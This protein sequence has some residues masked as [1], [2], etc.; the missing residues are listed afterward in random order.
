MRKDIDRV[1]LVI[2]KDD[3]KTLT[4]CAHVMI[5]RMTGGQVD[6]GSLHPALEDSPAAAVRVAE[7]GL[8]WFLVGACMIAGERVADHILEVGEIPEDLTILSGDVVK[9]LQ[10]LIGGNVGGK[11]RAAQAM[12]AREKL[13]GAG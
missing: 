9:R 13:E 7:A 1:I 8:S 4:G 3:M 5:K 11:E 6:G 10:E 12:A 2:E